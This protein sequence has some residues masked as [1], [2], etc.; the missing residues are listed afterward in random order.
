MGRF[1]EGEV[2]RAGIQRI[3]R[4]IAATDIH[5]IRHEVKFFTLSAGILGLLLFASCSRHPEQSE[6]IA[7]VDDQSLTTDF[8]HKQFDTAA[9]IS[10]MQ[11]RMYARQWVNSELLYQEAKRQGLDHSDAVLQSLEEARRQLAINALLDKD[12]F[13]DQPQSISKDEVAIYF[14]THAEEFALRDDIVQISLVV[15]SERDPAA[16]FREAALEGG[17]WQTAVAAAENPQ[18]A[19]EQFITKTDSAFYTEATLVPAKLWKVAAALGVGEVS[20]PVR[21]SAGYFVMMLLGSFPRGATPP[22]EY[23]ENEIRQRLVIQH[24]QQR[25]TEYLESVRKKHTVQINLSGVTP[26]HDTLAQPGE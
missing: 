14:K 21:T 15:F 1:P 23:V 9:G 17:G 12:V 22:M 18:D 7:R 25:L 6:E 3:S 8:V 4:D 11:V 20:F 19:K 10:E 2:P 5:Q 16:S 13:T 24:R 26:E